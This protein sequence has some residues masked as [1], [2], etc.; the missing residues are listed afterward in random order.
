[1][2]RV[3]GI[4]TFHLKSCINRSR[5]EREIAEQDRRERDDRER[6]EKLERER[7]EKERVE[8]E[9]QAKLE[10]GRVLQ[11][12]AAAAAAVNAHFMESFRN[13]KVG[14]FGNMS[15]NGLV[16]G[17]QFKFMVILFWDCFGVSCIL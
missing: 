14:R 11:E 12:S 10:R 3:C 9:K 4:S 5:I 15:A 16:L 2:L 17:L 13:M 1:M 8:R 6:A 7:K